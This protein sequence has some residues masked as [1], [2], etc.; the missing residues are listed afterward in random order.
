MKVTKNIKIVLLF[1]IIQILPCEKYV[2]KSIPTTADVE[3][4]MFTQNK[5]SRVGEKIHLLVILK[6][7]MYPSPT[8]VKVTALS[9][10]SNYQVLTLNEPTV[11]FVLQIVNQQLSF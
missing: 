11:G 2:W 1:D 6:L 9:C 4:H 3:N 5:L 7:P 10:S 8:N